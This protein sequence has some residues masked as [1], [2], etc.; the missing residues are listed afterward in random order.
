M[1]RRIG[2]PDCLLAG[3]LGFELICGPIRHLPLLPSGGLDEFRLLPGI[4]MLPDQVIV[5]LLRSLLPQ[6]PDGL[7]LHT[8]LGVIPSKVRLIKTK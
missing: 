3:T 5:S 2:I 8:R 7:D 1:V 6:Q 4:S